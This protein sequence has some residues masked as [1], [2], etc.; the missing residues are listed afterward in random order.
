M[1]MDYIISTFKDVRSTE[2]CNLRLGTFLQSRKYRER[3]E[4]VRAAE[5]KEQRDALKKALPC[6][7]ISG[8]FTVRNMAGIDSYN[9]LVCL[10]FDGKDNPAHTAQ[11]MKE[12]LS[13][14]GEVAYASLSV[15]GNGVF[16]II[17]TNTVEVEHHAKVVDV[18]GALFKGEGLM[19]DPA[20]KDACRLRFISYDEAP[21]L[22]PQPTVFD[23]TRYVPAM[24]RPPKPIR[25]RPDTNDR[26]ART[27]ER[28]ERYI[29][30]VVSS[31][32][33]VTRDYHDWFRIGMALG[34]EFGLD[35]E[36]YFHQISQVN[37]DYHPEK[38]AKKYFELYKNSRQIRIGTF[39]QIL[40]K[41]GI[42]I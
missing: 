30:E 10:D 34:N 4:S 15:S 28:V 22:N 32:Q 18:L 14:F 24:L 37:G 8:T 20:C 3:I 17:P 33:D 19:Y 12:L 42:T 16:A 1:F 39:F 11:S 31:G 26:D 5:S 25:H 6:A 38:C 7:T 2:P 29:Q 21:Y 41:H 27:R 40:K 35:G 9:G 23:A 13:E 36:N